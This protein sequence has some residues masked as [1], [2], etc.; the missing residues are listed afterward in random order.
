MRDAHHAIYAMLSAIFAVLGAMSV[1]AGI[2]L[3]TWGIFRFRRAAPSERA[4]RTWRRQLESWGML[5]GTTASGEAAEG[6]VVLPDVVPHLERI[7][8]RQDIGA[9]TGVALAALSFGAYSFIATGQVASALPPSLMV[10]VGWLW[11]GGFFGAAVTGTFSWTQDMPSIAT[12]LGASGS[13]PAAPAPG[14]KT[15]IALLPAALLTADVVLTLILAPRVL[16]STPQTGQ[17]PSDARLPAGIIQVGALLLVVLFG[18]AEWMYRQAERLW[19][20]VSP[21]SGDPLRRAEAAWQAT[22]AWSVYLSANPMIGIVAIY[23]GMAFLVFARPDLPSAVDVGAS[24]ALVALSLLIGPVC[25]GVAWAR[26]RAR[27][28]PARVAS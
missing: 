9:G 11:L 5:G 25:Y 17:Y 2:G 16:A 3:A 15:R 12:D 28:R 18:V 10:L 1:L 26:G 20:A 7:A 24:L 19:A 14:R 21:A 27:S 13:R 22:Q 6:A 23:L 8:A 4:M